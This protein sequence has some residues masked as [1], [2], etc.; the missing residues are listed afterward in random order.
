MASEMAAGQ[1]RH[2]VTLARRGVTFEV[3]EGETVLEAAYDAGVKLPFSCTVGGCMAC[4][5]RLLEGAV[6]MQEPH[7][8]SAAAQEQGW[9]L[10]CRAR[11]RG[12]LVVDA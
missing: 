5:K 4:K 12:A 7:G 3:A 9:V 2:R 8:L 10:L 1:R 11:P 6:D